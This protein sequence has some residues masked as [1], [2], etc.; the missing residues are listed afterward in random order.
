MSPPG[1]L[2]SVSQVERLAL[3]EQSG[4]GAQVV[5]DNT[6]LARQRILPELVCRGEEEGRSPV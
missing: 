1:Y 2:V 3:E 6:G 5:V 4:A